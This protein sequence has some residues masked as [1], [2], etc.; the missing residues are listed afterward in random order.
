[1]T[2]QWINNEIQV[3]SVCLNKL[4]AN[5]KEISILF[6]LVSYSC[7]YQESNTFVD[8]ISKEALLLDSVYLSIDEY[9]EGQLVIS[10]ICDIF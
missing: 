8:S 9:K 3:H 4:V 10:R 5:L 6:E 1:M 7:V 2:I